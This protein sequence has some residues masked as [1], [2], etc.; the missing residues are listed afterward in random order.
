MA[1]LAIWSFA[2]L[3]SFLERWLWLESIIRE[4]LYDL[5]GILT[6]EDRNRRDEGDWHNSLSTSS[7]WALESFS[8]VPV[9]LGAQSGDFFFDLMEN[10]DRLLI[11]V[12]RI[13][14]D[15]EFLHRGNDNTDKE[16]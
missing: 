4:W 7:I 6:V 9:Q 5:L 14:Q 12:I 8:S 13:G 15:R 3:G 10:F 11:G 1:C 2:V 16:V